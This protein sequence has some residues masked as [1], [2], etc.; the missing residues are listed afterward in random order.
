[1]R[2]LLQESDEDTVIPDTVELPSKIE[3]RV[4]FGDVI[5]Q[6]RIRKSDPFRK[7][8]SAMAA[9]LEFSSDTHLELRCSWGGE[10]ARIAAFMTPLSL[11]PV[12]QRAILANTVLE[13]VFKDDESLFT[14]A[15]T[16]ASGYD[17]FLVS[18][19]ETIPFFNSITSISSQHQRGWW[20]RWRKCRRR[21]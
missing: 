8:M 13:L 3:F 4:R 7:I 18:N 20:R 12:I 11:S 21:N 10:T 6:Y 14:P 19:H 17:S 16:A 5:S 2:T 9:E 15:D 1:M